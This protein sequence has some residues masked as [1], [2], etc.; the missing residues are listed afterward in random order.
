MGQVARTNTI[1]PSRAEHC[2]FAAVAGGVPAPVVSQEAPGA[3]IYPSARA[4][5]EEASGFV[6][7]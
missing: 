1:D 5:G 2:M 7:G 6:L 3:S 4:P